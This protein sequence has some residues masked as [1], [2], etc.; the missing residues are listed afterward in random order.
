MVKDQFVGTWTLV[1]FEFKR[2]DGVVMNVMGTDATG[3]IIY[4][5]H[6]HMSGQMM[7]ADRPTFAEN[8]QQKGSDDEVRA[9]VEG[10]I[11]Y[12]GDYVIDEAE[13]SVSHV[14]KGA[15][16]PNLVGQEQKRFYEFSGN[17]LTLTTPPVVVGGVS[18]VGVL[19]WEK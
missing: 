5:A 4:D 1:S 8:D 3:M 6:G 14:T 18:V 13:K 17:R 16:F 15:L 10:Y 12:F 2:S 7:R 9:A 19:V 11:A